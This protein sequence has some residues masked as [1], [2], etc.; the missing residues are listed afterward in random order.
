[1]ETSAKKRSL[2]ARATKSLRIRKGA[3]VPPSA[4]TAE[5][6]GV[7]TQPRRLLLGV[8]QQ[9]G[10]GDPDSCSTMLAILSASRA[11]RRALARD[12]GTEELSEAR[13]AA[14]VTL[15]ALEPM[16]ST[17]ADLAF[18]AEVS[19]SAMTD[20][21]DALEKHGWAIREPHGHDRR[22]T[23]VRLTADGGRVAVRAVHRFLHAASKIAGDLDLADRRATVA[24]CEEVERRALASFAAI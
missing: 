3:A 4:G 10:I 21:I 12:L 23:P 9:A 19:R 2:P 18:H 1:M 20:V 8:A 13:F 16:S 24:T 14:L 6:V 5:P 11:I 7:N 15:Y 17:P 22:L